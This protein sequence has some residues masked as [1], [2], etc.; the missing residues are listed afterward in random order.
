M[1]IRINY[2]WGTVSSRIWIDTAHMWKGSCVRVQRRF[3]QISI[4][5]L[6]LQEIDDAS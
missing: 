3:S 4:F 6:L 1:D 2:T 5:C